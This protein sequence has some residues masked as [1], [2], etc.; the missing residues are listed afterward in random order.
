[1]YKIGRAIKKLRYR[2][3][4]TIEQLVIDINERF[5][6]NMTTTMIDKWEAGKSKMVYEQLKA[7]ALYYNVTTDF[8]LGFDQ[9]KFPDIIDFEMN[10]I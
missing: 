9:D 3:N 4:I 10:K 1:M 8:L 6:L 5:N 2:K 7:L